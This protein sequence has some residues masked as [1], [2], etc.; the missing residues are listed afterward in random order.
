MRTFSIGSTNRLI[1]SM[2]DPPRTREIPREVD[3]RMLTPDEV[4]IITRAVFVSA[5]PRR[6]DLMLIFG[7]KQWTG[8]WY[9]AAALLRAGMATRMLVTGG[10]PYGND[11]AVSEAQGIRMAL[12]QLGVDGTTVLTEERSQNTLQNVVFSRELLK[13]TGAMPESILFYCKSHHAGRAWRTLTKHMPSVSLSCVTYDAIYGD[14]TVSMGDWHKNVSAT[15]RVLAEYER[16][17]RYAARGDI[18]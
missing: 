5:N 7:A 18:S 17:V 14:V 9:T 10:T 2:A 11:R 16:I 13:F 4:D 1:V 15:R 12:L 8:N 3:F 6:S